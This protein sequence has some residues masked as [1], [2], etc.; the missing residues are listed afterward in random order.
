MMTWCGT[1]CVS[2]I[3]TENARNA[4]GAFLSL[5]VNDYGRRSVRLNSVLR[6]GI[7][8]H[9]PGVS[10]QWKMWKLHRPLLK[11]LRM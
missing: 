2:S 4:G 7:S 8:V 11:T 1:E 10:R 5:S 3:F 6:L 9:P